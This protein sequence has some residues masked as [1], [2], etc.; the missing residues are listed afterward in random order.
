M[1]RKLDHYSEYGAAVLCLLMCAFAL[2]AHWLACIW[3]FIRNIERQDESLNTIGWLDS[4]G[5][6]IHQPFNKTDPTSGP[7]LKSKYVTALYFT[8]SSFVFAQQ[9]SARREF[10]ARLTVQKQSFL[11]S[12]DS[13][14]PPCDD[15][16]LSSSFVIFRTYHQN[17]FSLNF[18]G[19]AE[20]H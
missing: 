4:L 3:Y 2:L 6:Q 19:H 18:K 14:W 8:I 7:D 5:K 13:T 11:F 17:S 9:A 12:C 15:G 20:I 16:L 10:S 1:A